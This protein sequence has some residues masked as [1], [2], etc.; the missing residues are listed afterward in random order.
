MWHFFL[1]VFFPSVF[2]L[3][4]TYYH[5]DLRVRG[6]YNLVP[7]GTFSLWRTWVIRMKHRREAAAEGWKGTR[8]DSGAWQHGSSEVVP[9]NRP[10]SSFC[11]QKLTP[12]L[13]HI[14]KT[15]QRGFVAHDLFS[16]VTGWLA[17]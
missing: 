15:L 2:N 16:S 5:S 11:F 13:F 4:F 6:K 12:S 17:S 14:P 8:S 9:G 3:G 10:N 7:F 1:A